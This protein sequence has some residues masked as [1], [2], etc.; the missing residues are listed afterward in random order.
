M[1]LGGGKTYHPGHPPNWDEPLSWSQDIPYYSFKSAE[2]P[3]EVNEEYH[4]ITKIDTWCPLDERKYPDSFHYDWKLANHTIELL[5]Y[6]QNKG[7]PWFT[8]GCRFP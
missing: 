4:D 2:C 6:V 1:T 3:D 5:K 8:S 7:G